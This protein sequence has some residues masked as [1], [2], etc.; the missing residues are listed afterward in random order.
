VI[1]QKVAQANQIDV[2]LADKVENKLTAV[3][4]IRQ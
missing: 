3:Y 1:G 4:E 2:D